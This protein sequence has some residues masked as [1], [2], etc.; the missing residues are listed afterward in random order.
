[1]TELQQQLVL[2]VMLLLY[3]V[4][5]ILLIRHFSKR[6][7]SLSVVLLIG[8]SLSVLLTNLPLLI[9]VFYFLFSALA[10]P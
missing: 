7:H 2:L 3:E 5:L 8:I 10:T 9:W 1:M 4:G 6:E